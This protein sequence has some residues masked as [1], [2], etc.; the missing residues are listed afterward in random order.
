MRKNATRRRAGSLALGIFLAVT[1]GWAQPDGAAAKRIAELEERVARL[2][3]A[4][5]QL[6]EARA[7]DETAKSILADLPAPAAPA[8]AASERNPPAAG[9]PQELLPNLGKIGAATSFFAGLHSGPF[10]LGRGSYFGGAIELPLRRAPGGRLLYEI[11]LGL[12]RSTTATTV[13]SNVAQVANLAAL[14]TL[15][16]SGGVANI[17]AAV[18]GSGA[19]PF[20]VTV[21]ADTALQLLQVTPFALKYVNTRADRFRLRPYAMAGLGTYVTISNQ[22]AATGLRADADLPPELRQAF[23]NLF[24][25]RAPFGGALIG[26]QLGQA[27]ELTE[28][29]VP[30]GQGG[31]EIGLQTG[32]GLEW[33][34]SRTLSLSVDVRWN[35]LANGAAY[36]NTATRWGWHF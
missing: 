15:N 28:R 30:A 19:A 7:S 31:I 22:T 5:A 11:S 16:P 27:R 12:S 26:G 3:R 2:E 8:P 20:P 24:A 17:N 18:N 1:P 13:T 32:G 35:R 29:G 34:M 4:L 36:W 6:T 33:R 9:L 23:A 10:S 14:A 25:N 21:R